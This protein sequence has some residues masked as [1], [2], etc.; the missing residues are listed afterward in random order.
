M[1]TSSKTR[2]SGRSS[3]PSSKQPNQLGSTIKQYYRLTKPGII[4]GNLLTVVAGFLYACSQPLNGGELPAIQAVPLIAASIGSSL[5]I[6]AG[7]VLNNILDRDIDKRMERTKQRAL[8]AG[9]ISVKAASLYAAVLGAIGT[10]TLAALTNQL[11]V[12]IGLVGLYMYVVAYGYSKRRGPAGTLVGSISGAVP[13]VAG[14]AA[15][16][17]RL[18]VQAL[19]LFIA[20]ACWQMPHF[21]AI[22]LYRKREYQAADIPVLPLAKGDTYTQRSI[23]RYIVLYFAIIIGAGVAGYTGWTFTVVMGALSLAW[24][25]RGYRTTGS[26]AIDVWGRRIFGSSLRILLAFSILLAANRWL[27]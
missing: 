5:V 9:S 26:L 17:G 22:A 11:T 10:I 23:L 14:Y 6:A 27:P 19:L 20:M 1:S 3:Q 13:I 12:Y 25:W 4:Y 24:F 18:D 21:Y 2:A 8:A 16:S 7:C 15:A